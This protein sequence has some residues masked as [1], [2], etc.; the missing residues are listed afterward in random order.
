MGGSIFELE[1]VFDINITQGEIKGWIGEDI[2]HLLPPR[3]FED[4]VRSAQEMGGSVIKESRLRWAAMFTLPN[5]QRIFLKRD[6]TKGWLESLK[7]VFSPSKGKKEWFMAHQLKERNLSIPEPFGWMEK[8][9]WGF[10]KESYY[11][12]EAIGSGT[13]LIDDPLKLG[14]SSSIDELAK[15]VRKIHDSGLFHEDLHAGNFLWDGQT[16]FLTDLHRGKIIRSLSLNQRRWNLSQLFHSLRSVW[17]ER[18]RLR[19]LKTYF[20][21]D[22]IYFQKREDWVQKIDSLMKRLQRRQWKSRAK[23]CL[24][25]STEFSIEKEKG[26]RYYHRRDFSLVHL[27]RMVEEHLRWIEEKPSSLAKYSSEVMV[28]ILKDGEKR[29]SV[30]QFRYPHCWDVFKEHFRRSKGLRAWLA[31]NGLR[32][33]G[34]P[35]LL[36]LAFVER[37]NWLGLIETFLVMEAHEMSRELD[38][39]ILEGFRDVREKRRFIKTFARWLSHFHR[40]NL[41]HRDMKT[42]NILISENGETWDFHLLDLEDVRLGKRVGEKDV[43]RNLLQLNTSIPNTISRRDRLRFFRDY[44]RFHP[45]IK[46]HRMF[47]FRLLQRSRE[48]GVV[49]VSSKGVISEKPF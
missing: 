26:V 17:S 47:L 28:S 45:V 40:M 18:D 49:Y 46:N 5:E 35:S 6:R 22:P 7:Y 48:R 11:L 27:K 24:K 29:I 12:S 20:E 3:F 13:S 34:I 15:I 43:F 39:Y 25:E 32:A 10:V 14:E 19:F 4:P 42:C 38:R 23:R 8:I 2:L 36:P 44:T 31:G 37:K 9:R 30:K 21:G 41:Y 1:R 16:L 33:R